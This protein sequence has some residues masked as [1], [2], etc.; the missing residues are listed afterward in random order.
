ML[1]WLPLIHSC[2]LVSVTFEIIYVRRL[3]ASLIARE[4]GGHYKLTMNC[5]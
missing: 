5:K 2:V 1:D 3:V 4:Y